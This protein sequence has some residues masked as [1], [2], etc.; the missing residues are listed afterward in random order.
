MSKFFVIFFLSEISLILG[1]FDKHYQITC[2]RQNAVIY[3]VIIC[4]IHDINDI[5]DTQGLSRVLSISCKV[6][7]ASVVPQLL[8]NC[9]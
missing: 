2:I 7:T 4:V 3:M 6:Y 5:N 1:H 8:P 9:V